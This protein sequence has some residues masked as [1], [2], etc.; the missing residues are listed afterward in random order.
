MLGLSP[1]AS[2]ATAAVGATTLGLLGRRL[3]SARA[4]K[5]YILHVYDQVRKVVLT[6][7]IQSGCDF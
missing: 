7:G 4:A 6:V 5:P 2:L 1:R 3:L